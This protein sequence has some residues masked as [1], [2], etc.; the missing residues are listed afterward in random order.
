VAESL[1]RVLVTGGRDYTDRPAVAK[2]LWHLA[3]NYIFGVRP[4]EITLVHG[5]CTGADT[6]AAAEAERLGWRIEA[7]PADWDQYGDG[8]GP[9]RN[10]EMVRR[11]ANYIVAFPGGKGTKQCRRLALNAGIPIID[12][13]E[14]N[15]G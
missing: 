3:N 7:H 1:I 10:R 6:L 12:I 2:A 14:A 11:G 13:P 5:D 15:R 8:A 4:E 9:R